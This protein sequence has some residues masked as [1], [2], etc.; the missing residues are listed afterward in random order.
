VKTL[1]ELSCGWI[2]CDVCGD[3][4]VN[5]VI[6]RESRKNVFKFELTSRCY[7]DINEDDLTRDQLIELIEANIFHVSTLRGTKRIKE[8]LRD[9]RAGDFDVAEAD[10]LESKAVNV[11]DMA[12]A[13][14]STA[15]STHT[16]MTAFRDMQH[17]ISDM[18]WLYPLRAR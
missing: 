15:S 3:G 6:E 10:P 11:Q 12:I 1:L 14:A 18:D 2:K 9:L 13:I 7:G 4:Y 16:M 17:A 5:M 8:F